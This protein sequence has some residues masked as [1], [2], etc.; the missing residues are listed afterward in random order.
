LFDLGGASSDGAGWVAATA[1]GGQSGWA[2]QG[3]GVVVLGR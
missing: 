2:L 1:R 3:S